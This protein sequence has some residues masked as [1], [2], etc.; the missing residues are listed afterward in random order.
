M[1]RVELSRYAATAFQS[2]AFAKIPM[3]EQWRLADE[4]DAAASEAD[5]SDETWELLQVGYAEMAEANGLPFPF[6][7]EQVTKAFML[8]DLILPDST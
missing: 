1:N 5:L 2:Q 3:P 6:G 4:I 7:I 8:P